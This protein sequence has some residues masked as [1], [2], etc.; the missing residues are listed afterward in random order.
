LKEAR[1]AG[2]Q[3]L[4]VV[5]LLAKS[6]FERSCGRLDEARLTFQ[7]VMDIVRL[8]EMRLYIADCYLES[9]RILLAE[10]ERSSSADDP[11]LIKARHHLDIVR[12]MLEE[13]DYGRRKPEYHLAAAR[14]AILE[15]H[16][17]EARQ[18]LALSR[19]WILPLEH[20]GRGFVCHKKEFDD[21]D[22]RAS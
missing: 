17:E 21:L 7:E 13:M 22:A 19:P 20:C 18:Q 14:L 11:R 10:S 5:V 4:I 8:S 16:D 15:H 2:V 6:A 1:R 12:P 3:Q 9:A